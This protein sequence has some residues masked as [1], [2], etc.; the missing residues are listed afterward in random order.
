[1]SHFTSPS[2]GLQRILRYWVF[3]THEL[4]ISL[5]WW[6]TYRA[7]QNVVIAVCTISEVGRGRAH[8]RTH[9]HSFKDSKR[10]IRN[11]KMKGQKD[12]WKTSVKSKQ[13]SQSVR[14]AFHS[15]LCYNLWKITT[16]QYEK[17]RRGEDLERQ[18]KNREIKPHISAKQSKANIK[19]SPSST[20]AEQAG[21]CALIRLESCHI[22]TQTLKYEI[23]LRDNE[24]L[25]LK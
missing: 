20:P 24:H 4:W 12:T 16:H 11:R 25:M 17:K 15:P 19:G 8:S 18:V 3:A 23:T 14:K 10:C 5:L 21:V 22:N 2:N 13:F 7:K 6:L 1:M 9:K